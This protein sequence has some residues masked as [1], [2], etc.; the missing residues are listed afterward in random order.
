MRSPACCWACSGW[1]ISPR[2]LATVWREVLA[3][4]TRVHGAVG[5]EAAQRRVG[6][7]LSAL[8]GLLRSWL[9]AN[10]TTA[11]S[12]RDAVN[13]VLSLLDIAA[14]R[15]HVKSATP[16]EELGIVTDA[17]EAR[18]AA[19]APTS[20]DW[21]DAFDQFDC[22]DAVVLL[23]S[24]AARAWSTTRCSSS[25]LTTNNGG[26]RSRSRRVHVDILRGAVPG[27]PADHL[28]DHKPVCPRGSHRRL[29]HH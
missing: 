27:R 29:L 7:D 8:T 6:D 18:L 12:A 17:F 10:P 21:T 3:T 20:T 2:G 24:T 16:D 13:Y 4:L 1:P 15:R 14:L 28:H 11:T 5:D 22:A 9:K 23:T 25:A 19:V 26:P